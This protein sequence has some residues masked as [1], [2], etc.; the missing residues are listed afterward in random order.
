MPIQL[1][2]WF[3]IV[4]TEH[5]HA[6]LTVYEKDVVRLNIGQKVRFTLPNDNEKER[7]ASIYLIGR[8][9]DTDRSVR[10]HAHLESEDIDLL[11]GM[12]INANIEINENRVNAVLEE[13]IVMSEGKHFVYVFK[14]EQN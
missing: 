10:V 7:L 9:I 8:K 3:E 12:Y 2:L 14:G 1:M 5:L 6:E 11:P 13:A 4:N